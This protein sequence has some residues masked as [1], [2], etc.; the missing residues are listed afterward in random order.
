MKIIGIDPG[1][2]RCG[3]AIIEKIPGSKET[4]VFSDCLRTSA[5]LSMPERL[6]MIGKMLGDIV[7]KY[8]P[9]AAAIEELYFG[10][11]STTAMK[12]AE[13]RGVIQFVL[14]SQNIPVTQYHPSAIKIAITG[15][16]SASKDDILF[17]LPKLVTLPDTKKLDD[18][19]DAVAVAITHAVT[20]HW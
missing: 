7:A 4:I 9:D 15:Y 6:Q 12:V 11:S 2:E 14:A 17:M 18:E 10:K 5:K 16:G 20:A 8:Q 1:Y 3:V 13:A 19:L